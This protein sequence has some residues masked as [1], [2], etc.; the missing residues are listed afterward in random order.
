MLLNLPK[1]GGFIHVYI[2][3]K[4]RGK[5]IFIKVE[6]NGV[7]MI[8]EAAERVFEVFYQ[9]EYENYKGSGLGLA[10]SKELIKLHK[11]S[12]NVKSEKGKGTTFEVRLLTGKD[13]LQPKN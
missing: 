4:G 9:G 3:K 12:I 1:D 10:L 6:D 5:A 2:N 7:G 11:G 13:H 8:T